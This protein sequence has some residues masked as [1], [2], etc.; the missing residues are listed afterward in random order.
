MAG[1]S[2]S[3]ALSWLGLAAAPFA[4]AAAV[5][6]PAAGLAAGAAVTLLALFGWARGESQAAA[7][8]AALAGI[9]A[10]V[11]AHPAFVALAIAALAA[12]AVRAAVRS[13]ALARREA[14]RTAS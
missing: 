5:T 4:L 1:R 9:A 6:A 12:L 8:V 13:I 11:A 2:T 10:L 3:S 7:G 14:E